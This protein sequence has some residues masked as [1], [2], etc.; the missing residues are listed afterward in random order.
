MNCKSAN[1]ALVECSRRGIGHD[2]E[3][4]AHMEVC[5][6]CRERWDAERN[7]TEHL[8]AMRIGSA[9]GNMEWGKAVLMREFDGNVRRER[10][11]RWMWAASTAAALVLSVVAVSEVWKPAVI[12]EKVAATNAR[13]EYA[14]PEYGKDS[15]APAVEAG[16]TGFIAVPFAAPLLPDER[17]GIVRTQLDT[18]ELA[19]MGVSVEPGWTGAMPADLLVGQDGFPRAVRV[20]NDNSEGF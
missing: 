12:Q 17:V 2:R 3:L 15:F 16:E 8:R 10:Q 13:H 19:S 5:A 7:L 11:V 20:S 14:L 1:A 9:L 4:E 18:A 6:S